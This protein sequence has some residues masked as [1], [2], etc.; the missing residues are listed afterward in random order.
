MHN[1]GRGACIIKLPHFCG[2]IIW[3]RILSDILLRPGHPIVVVEVSIKW[4]SE[5]RIKYKIDPLHRGTT[6]LKHQ[7][8]LNILIQRKRARFIS[9]YYATTT[10]DL[11]PPDRLAR[12]GHD[13][14]SCLSLSLK[15]STCCCSAAFTTTHSFAVVASNHAAHFQSWTGHE[16]FRSAGRTG[17]RISC[18][19]C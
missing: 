6:Q 14:T 5:L 18:Y 13:G 17:G 3:A 4:P 15:K 12:A 16:T 1:F 9:Y 8:L 19:C 2:F 11:R 7:R 10:A